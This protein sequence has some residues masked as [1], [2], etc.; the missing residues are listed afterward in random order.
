[1]SAPDHS[2]VILP[3]RD[4]F[5]LPPGITIQT[6]GVP[7][8]IPIGGMEIELRIV[9][10][11]DNHQLPQAPAGFVVGSWLI[12]SLMILHPARIHTDWDN[13]TLWL[14]FGEYNSE[15]S[16]CK[17]TLVCTSKPGTKH[18]DPSGRRWTAEYPNLSQLRSGAHA[19]VFV[20]ARC[21][22]PSA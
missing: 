17:M 9:P 21:V 1:M 18:T 19:A 5:T 7:G 6:S 8:A 4:T 15:G 11:T 12:G 14:P 10:I 3:P 16:A 2:I 20:S 22:V 13:T